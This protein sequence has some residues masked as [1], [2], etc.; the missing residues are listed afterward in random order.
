MNIQELWLL[1][2]SSPGSRRL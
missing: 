1:P 2:A